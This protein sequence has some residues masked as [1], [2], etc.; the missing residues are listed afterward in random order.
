MEVQISQLEYKKLLKDSLVNTDIMRNVTITQ[1]GLKFYTKNI[2][3]MS[4][5]EI[6]SNSYIEI[7]RTISRQFKYLEEK[8]Y[9]IV[10]LN[11]DDITVIDDEI[12]VILNPDILYKIMED[13]SIEI[14][15]PIKKPQFKS[16]ELTELNK[17]PGKIHYKTF[18]YSLGSLLEHLYPNEPGWTKLRFFIKRCKNIIP[19]NR[20][21]L[22][23]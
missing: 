17:V 20:A 21:M 5:Y 18:Y 16:P 19:E 13:K 11:M 3:R 1:I 9:S 7:I 4:K 8:G 23:V 12:F 22:F 10:G 6:T 2:K 14:K 15:K